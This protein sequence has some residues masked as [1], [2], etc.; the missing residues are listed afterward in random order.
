MKKIRIFF[1]PFIL[2]TLI[3][4]GSM[5]INNLK[6]VFSHELR[7]AENSTCKNPLEEMTKLCKL[8][9]NIDTDI[10][11]LPFS[12]EVFYK[13]NRTDFVHEILTKGRLVYKKGKNLF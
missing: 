12:S 2:I 5:Q 6:P 3:I 8:R 7:S 11:P 9:R 13:H 10:E 4:G 1:I